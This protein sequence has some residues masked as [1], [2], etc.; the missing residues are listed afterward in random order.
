[1]TEVEDFWRNSGTLV[2]KFSQNSTNTSY[3]INT[4]FSAFNSILFKIDR[5]GPVVEIYK[6][7]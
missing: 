4:D 3:D 7:D 5:L 1:L 6:L 2:K